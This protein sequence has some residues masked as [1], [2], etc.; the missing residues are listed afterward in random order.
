MSEDQDKPVSTNDSQRPKRKGHS[1]IVIL[2]LAVALALVIWHL[3]VPMS[4]A[5]VAGGLSVGAV[6]GIAVAVMCLAM[7]LFAIFSGVGVIVVGVLALVG[8]ILGIVLFPFLFPIMIPLLVV[9]VLIKIFT[10]R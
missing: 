4:A 10:G 1:G 8:A 6:S 9:M 5:V 3:I 2:I 7:F